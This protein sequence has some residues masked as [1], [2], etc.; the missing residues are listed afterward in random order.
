MA[1]IIQEFIKPD[2]SGVAFSQQ[3]KNQEIFIEYCKS[4][5]QGVESG[6]KSPFITLWRNGYLYLGSVE[7]KAHSQQIYEL[8]QKICILSKKENILLDIEFAIAKNKIYLL[9]SRPLTRTIEV[10]DIFFVFE[11]YQRWKYHPDDFSIK[12]FKEI[13]KKLNINTPL[14]IKRI[15]KDIFIK[16][17]SYFSFIAEIKQ[18][19]KDLKFLDDFY[20]YY[21]KFILTQHART[22]ITSTGLIVLIL[23]VKELNFK[24]SII[25]FIHSLVLKNLKE[26]LIKKYNITERKNFEYFVPSLSF[27]TYSFLSHYKSNKKI[28]NSYDRKFLERI[29]KHDLNQLANNAKT[30]QRKIFRALKKLKGKQKKYF[31]VL[32]KLVWLRDMVDYYYDVITS[33]YGLDLVSILKRQNIKHSFEDSLEICR[34]S[35]N[36][37]QAIRKNKFFPKPYFLIKKKQKNIFKKNTLFL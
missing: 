37:I 5:Y 23:A 9:Q 22:K 29:N 36:E 10:K 26:F 1:V 25:D 18:K 16:G 27:T 13:L 17:E 30:N 24:M 15:R 35:L 21:S 12:K 2:L 19:S 33:F 4:S 8:I 14:K 11:R 20:Q 31:V 6:T 7:S 34:L 28:P 32:K 3:N